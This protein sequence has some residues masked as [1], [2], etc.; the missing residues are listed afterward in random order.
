MLWTGGLTSKLIILFN[1]F[2]FGNLDKKLHHFSK[3][4]LNLFVT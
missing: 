1:F 2:Y 4:K 3:K